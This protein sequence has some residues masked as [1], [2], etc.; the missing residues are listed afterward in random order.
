MQQQT[1]SLDLRWNQCIGTKH[2]E[3]FNQHAHN[4]HKPFSDL[5]SSLAGKQTNKL[6]WWVSNVTSRNTFS[7]PLFYRICAI[8]F[9]EKLL[10]T[11]VVPDQLVVDS[12]AQSELL[13][14]IIAEYKVDCSVI[15]KEESKLIK[16]RGFLFPVVFLKY[17]CVWLLVRLFTRHSCEKLITGLILVDT[18]ISPGFEHL[19]RYYPGLVESLAKTDRKRIWYVPSFYGYSFFGIK[20]ALKKLRKSNR[21]YLFKERYLRFSDYLFVLGHRRRLQCKALTFCVIAGRDFHKIMQEEMSTHP[22]FGGAIIGL[23]NYRFFLRVKESG[24]TVDRVVDWFENQVVDKGW[25]AGVRHYLPT[26]DSIGYQ[27]YA[28][29]PHY[30]NMYPTTAELEGGV[31]PK[32]VA[33]IGEGFV[34]S[35]KRF[36]LEIDVVTAP[37]FRFSHIYDFKVSVGNAGFSVLVALPKSLH[38]SKL[39]VDMACEVLDSSKTIGPISWQLKLHPTHTSDKLI[40]VLGS[41]I[42]HFEIK[43][44]SFQELLTKANL[45]ISNASSVCLES[46]A[47]GRPTIIMSGGKGLV[48]NPIPDAVPSE[49]WRICYSADELCDAILNFHESYGR[50]SERYVEIGLSVRDRYFE[51]VQRAGIYEFIGVKG[52]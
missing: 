9:V 17:F 29:T 37:A 33:V 14:E 52:V 19:D 31:L 26:V 38:E 5:I 1:K 50:F 7:S 42:D 32:Q 13:Q 47:C 36:C 11:G 48:H 27:G 10:S 15:V 16:A 25:N 4:L 43:N 40:T 6:D 34:E 24:L 20:S 21:N 45:V 39:I 8:S 51:P 41:A 23:L 12:I 46:V 18:F 3:A 2:A 30:L 49:I 44:N 22:E 28:V 35:R